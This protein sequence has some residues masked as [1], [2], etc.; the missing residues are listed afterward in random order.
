MIIVSITLKAA[1]SFMIRF[2]GY[3]SAKNPEGESIKIKG[4]R[5]RALTMAVKRSCVLPS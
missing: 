4:R 3:L 1:E 2:F 5:I